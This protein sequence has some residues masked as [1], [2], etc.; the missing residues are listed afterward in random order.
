MTAVIF[1]PMLSARPSTCKS[2]FVIVAEQHGH[3]APDLDIVPA[4][5]RLSCS[6][7]C[8]V[9]PP[10]AGTFVSIPNTTPVLSGFGSIVRSTRFLSLLQSQRVLRRGIV[11]RQFLHFTVRAQRYATVGLAIHRGFRLSARYSLL[12]S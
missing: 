10:F 11:A 8:A 12:K 6:R 1:N 3:F 9:L 7:R 5:I 4:P 2:F